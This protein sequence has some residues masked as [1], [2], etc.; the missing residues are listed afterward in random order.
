M[1]VFCVQVMGKDPRKAVRGS[2]NVAAATRTVTNR[3]QSRRDRKLALQQDVLELLHASN[4]SDS[5][6]S[7]YVASFLTFLRALDSR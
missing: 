1:I 2:A 4:L 5:E 7:L 6:R 3:I